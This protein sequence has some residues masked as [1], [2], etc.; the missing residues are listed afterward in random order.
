MSL[1]QFDPSLFGGATLIGVKIELQGNVGGTIR[2]ENRS[3]SAG[4][5]TA[6]LEAQIKLFD[7]VS[8]SEL[9]SVIPSASQIEALPGFDGIRDWSGTSG[10][11]YT[12][13]TASDMQMAT[14]PSSSFATYI[15]S[16]MVNLPVSAT[17]KSSVTGSG[18]VSFLLNTLATSSAQITYFYEDAVVPE[19]ATVVIWSAL[20]GVGLVYARRQRRRVQQSAPPA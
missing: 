10:R 12:N 4:T 3:P 18:N 6:K 1:P 17:G 13:L 19:P 16:G 5:V 15:G 7:P 11:S 14:L 9:V 20:A 8:S 2:F